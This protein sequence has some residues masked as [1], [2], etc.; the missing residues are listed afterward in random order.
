MYDVLLRDQNDTNHEF[1]SG[2]LS[3]E[4]THPGRVGSRD[5]EERLGRGLDDEIIDA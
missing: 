1:S 3:N 5:L 4:G 2:L